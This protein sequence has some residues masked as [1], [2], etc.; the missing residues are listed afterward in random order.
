MAKIRKTLLTA[1]A[2]KHLGL[3]S[4]GLQIPLP[5]L[6][7]HTAAASPRLGAGETIPSGPFPPCS[8]PLLSEQ[9]KA[10]EGFVSSPCAFAPVLLPGDSH[11]GASSRQLWE[12]AASGPPERG[13]VAVLGVC[14][15]TALGRTIICSTP[16]AQLFR[17]SAW[18]LIA[19][20]EAQQAAPAH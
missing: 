18:P 3:G 16:P 11:C 8:S 15:R 2:V 12:F 19:G 7:T 1:G 20:T 5:G 6:Q 17:T 4:E 14:S 9:T 10:P 13:R